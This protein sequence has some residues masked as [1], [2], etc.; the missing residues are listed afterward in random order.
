MQP[1]LLTLTFGVVLAVVAPSLACP[2]RPGDRRHTESQR[3]NSAIGCMDR[4]QV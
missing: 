3:S 2:R 1:F 4:R